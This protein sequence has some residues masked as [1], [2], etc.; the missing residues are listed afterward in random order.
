MFDR[1][2]MRRRRD[3]RSVDFGISPRDHRG[4]ICHH[5]K[6]PGVKFH[7][8][9]TSGLG[10]YRSWA[11]SCGVSPRRYRPARSVTCAV[12]GPEK[13]GVSETLCTPGVALGGMF[14]R[15]YRGKAIFF[16]P[17]AGRAR[18][19]ARVTPRRATPHG[20]TRRR[21]AGG[22]ATAAGGR[23]GR[24]PPPATPA[25]RR[26]PAGRTPAS[27]GRPPAS[28]GRP[29]AS[30]DVPNGLENLPR[31]AHWPRKLAP[32]SPLA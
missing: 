18:P 30:S 32:A 13:R 21:W 19:W 24:P 10:D 20:A 15:L 8:K 9:R 7:Q 26:P 12:S 31:R 28:S 29:P 23:V 27:S 2:S 6:P 17:W 5:K 25:G 14:C 11:P 1:G 16:P 4:W 3:G 22:L